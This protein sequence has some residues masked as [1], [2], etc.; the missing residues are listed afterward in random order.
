[1][2]VPS[3][4]MMLPLPLQVLFYLNFIGYIVLAVAYYLPSLLQF[5]P[6][7]RYQRAI[8]W[9]LIAYAAVTIVLWFL[10]TGGG[11]NII[12]YIDKPIEVALIILL[13]IDDRQTSRQ[14]RLQR[15]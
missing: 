6:L 12:A 15:G 8:R 3:I 14:A 11:Y 2:G 1:M 10:I 13:L 7:L 9:L 5:Q 4:M